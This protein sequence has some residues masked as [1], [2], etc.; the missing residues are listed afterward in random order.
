MKLSNIGVFARHLLERGGY[1]GFNFKP[2]HRTIARLCFSMIL[3]VN[4][5]MVI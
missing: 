4:S 2:G 1:F 5:G 3:I